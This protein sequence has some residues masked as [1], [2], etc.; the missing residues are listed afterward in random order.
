MTS[1]LLVKSTVV[2]VPT[3][4]PHVGFALTVQSGDGS[5]FPDPIVSGPF[6]VVI[7]DAEVSTL[8]RVSEVARVIGRNGDVFTLTRAQEGT[9]PRHIQVGD[10]I[11]L[12]VNENTSVIGLQFDT[13][14]QPGNFLFA[15]TIGSNLIP[16]PNPSGYTA[17]IFFSSNA[18][19]LWLNSTN[20]IFLDGEDRI[21]GGPGGAVT[22]QAGTKD[23]A[24]PFAQEAFFDVD[25]YGI[26]NSGISITVHDAN[27]SGITFDT[28]GADNSGIFFQ[29]DGV[30]NSGIELETSNGNSGVTLR[31]NNDTGGIT[32]YAGYL[33]SAAGSPG[34][35]VT[36]QL[37]DQYGP[38]RSGMNPYRSGDFTVA[39]ND[40][41]YA[42]ST[43]NKFKVTDHNGASILEVH[44][45]GTV[46]G[47]AS[48]GTIAWDL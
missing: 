4:E 7:K 42:M 40:P 21:L 26:D 48:I 37:I 5:L 27:N 25:V 29:T 36:V 10:V 35:G 28:K 41:G 46:H 8:S 45:D 12:A 18:E 20:G 33:D 34:A 15:E 31:T 13:E 47:L 1:A 43:D 9:D 30:R 3:P 11:Y 19:L 22:I 32:L 6:N 14:P 23:N 38:S 17:G 16:G 24:S 2:S 39:L 44:D